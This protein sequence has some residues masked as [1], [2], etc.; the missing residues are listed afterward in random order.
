[1]N[2]YGIRIF[3]NKGILKNLSNDNKDLFL[4]SLLEVKISNEAKR[5]K[6]E[7]KTLKDFTNKELE[8]RY[9]DWTF[10]EL[11]KLKDYMECNL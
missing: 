9:I 8:D 5:L 1:M 11:E 2:K 3:T 4:D 10:G 6:S 7:G